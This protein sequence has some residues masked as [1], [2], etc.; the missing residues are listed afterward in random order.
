MVPITLSYYYK[1]KPKLKN[2]NPE[3]VTHTKNREAYTLNPKPLINKPHTI[4]LN[5][6]PLTPHP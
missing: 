5:S 3:F 1:C 2:L 6:E 4:T